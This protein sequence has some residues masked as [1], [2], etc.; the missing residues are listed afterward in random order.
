MQGFRANSC[1]ALTITGCLGDNIRVAK[2]RMPSVQCSRYLLPLP[3]VNV[4]L[5][6]SVERGISLRRV[7]F[8]WL[9]L[10]GPHSFLS[11]KM[12]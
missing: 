11:D 1:H 8:E 12:F 3:L 2:Q 4:A 7:S 5:L 10:R 9:S 6:S